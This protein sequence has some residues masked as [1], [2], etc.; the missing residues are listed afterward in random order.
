MLYRLIRPLLFRL[1]PERAHRFVFRC[2][3]VF[4]PP[5]V[6]KIYLKFFP[7]LPVHFFGLTVNNPVG[8]AAGLDNNGDYIDQLLGLGFG[9]VEVG[10]VTPEPQ[11]GNP[12]PRL[13]R[14]PEEKALINRMGFPNKGVDYLVENLKKR[15]LPG[16]VGV[17]ITKNKHTPLR[18]A[19]D[20]YLLCL[21]KLFM[22]CDYVTINV[23]SPN[24]PGLRQLQ[25]EQYLNDLLQQLDQA[26]AR[27]CKKHQKLF[28]LLLKVSPDLEPQDLKALV[29]AAMRHHI[30]AL[31]LTNTTTSRLCMEGSS[32]MAGEQGGLSGAPLLSHASS[33]LAGARE[34]SDGKLPLIGLGGVVSVEAAVEKVRKGAHLV[35]VYTGLIYEGPP[36]VKAIVKELI[37]LTSNTNR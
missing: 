27:L 3:K 20:D 6:A 32:P 23:S 8:A 33:R 14:F 15:K 13:F 5:W 37:K 19:V 35:Q 28:P 7:Q 26:R 16:V 2:V 22:H 4:Y 30:D 24:T 25:T 29:K 36:L 11:P 17:N 10:G 21:E 34:Y 12:Q 31:I 18:E 9:F 1:P